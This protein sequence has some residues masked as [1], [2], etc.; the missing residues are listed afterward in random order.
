[1]GADLQNHRFTALDDHVIEGWVGHR[2]I[3]HPGRNG[4]L[5]GAGVVGDAVA[6]RGGRCVIAARCGCAAA[7]Q[8]GEAQGVSRRGAQENVEDH[9]TA[10]HRLGNGRGDAGDRDHLQRAD[11][12]V[13]VPVTVIDDHVDQ[14]WI[15]AV[16]IVQRV[17]EADRLQCQGIGR[18]T[19]GA[20]EG[21]ADHPRRVGVDC[22][23]DPTGQHTQVQHISQLGIG[24]RD[25]GRLQVGVV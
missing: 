19:G 11:G 8:I 21:D 2:E 14:P 25:C 3:A 20:A 10:F 4:D 15:G 5:S 12:G 1:M 7:Q 22:A 13:R 16:G 24:Q 23:A 18:L 6:E 9:V 17:A